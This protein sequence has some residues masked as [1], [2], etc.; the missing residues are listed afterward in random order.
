VTREQSAGACEHCCQH[1]GYWLVHNGF[2]DSVYSYCD[3]CGKTAILS[4][5]DKQMPKLANCPPHQEICVALEPHLRPCSCG[6]IFKRGSAPRCPH[7]N[8]TL[9]ADLATAFIEPNAPGTNKGWRWQRNWS[10][11]YCIVIENNF[12]LDNLR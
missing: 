9:S 5:S 10:G 11:I 7:C 3:T 2:N 8:A 1:F 6:G 4:M 12:V